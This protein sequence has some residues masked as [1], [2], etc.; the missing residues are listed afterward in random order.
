MC[1]TITHTR[2]KRSQVFSLSCGTYLEDVI[3]RGAVFP[4]GV[5]RHS[6]LQRPRVD[7]EAA[8]FCGEGCRHQLIVLRESQNKRPF[9]INN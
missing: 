4:L 1:K 6:E 7:V 5:R 3:L 8:V 9:S 2:L